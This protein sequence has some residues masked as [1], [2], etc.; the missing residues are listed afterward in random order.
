MTSTLQMN[1]AMTPG[2]WGLLIVLSAIWGGSFFFNAIALRELPVFTLVVSRVAVA[3][4]ILLAVLRFR[5]E[6]LPRSGSVW[7]A[8][9]GM[10]LLN[11]AIPFSLIVAGQTHLASGVAA[12]LNASTPLFT[13]I[14]ANALTSDER[15]TGGKLVGV[16]AGLLGVAAMVGDEAVQNFGAQVG[17]QIMCI[18]AAISY[19]FA[20]IFGRR[21][22]SLGVTPMTTAAGQVVASSV[23]LL[24]VALLV[25]RPWTLPAPGFQAVAAVLA[26]AAISTAL[27]Y[28]IFFPASRHGG[29]HELVGG[30]VP[31]PG[32]RNF[33][34]DALSGRG[35]GAEAFRRDGADRCRA[36]GHRWAA[37]AAS[38]QR[39]GQASAALS[40]GSRPGPESVV[41]QVMRERAATAGSHGVQ[42]SSRGASL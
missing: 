31:C 39:G 17:A 13:V 2:E 14:L 11:N 3:A 42:R 21:F 9:F 5:G 15:M 29:R 6:R 1:R 27:A 38:A 26:V 34:W 19:A 7:L 8:F 18:A 24:P 16:L 28:V 22:R 32:Q 41:C 23:M 10:G 36:R 30:D 20:G 33:A 35:S 25:D 12:I 4:L 40:E 37:M